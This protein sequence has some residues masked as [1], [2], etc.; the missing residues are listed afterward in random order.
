[1]AKFSYKMQNILNIKYKLEEQEKSNYSQAR[2]RLTLEEEKLKKL[3]KR[4]QDYEDELKQLMNHNLQIQKIK[5]CEDAV[6]I[7]KYQIN[8][9]KIAVIDAEKQLEEA[10]IRLNEA[11]KERKI[12][13]KLKEKAFDEFILEINAEETK[14]IDELVSFKYSTRTDGEDD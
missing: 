6:E 4:R 13:E 9:Q 12:H 11:M 7:I 10:R 3:N 1:M 5:A 2:H 8:I 14:E